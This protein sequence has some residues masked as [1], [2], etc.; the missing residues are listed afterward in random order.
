METSPAVPQ[1]AFRPSLRL[2]QLHPE[3]AARQFLAAVLAPF[4]ATRAA[5]LAVAW[6]SS[7]FPASFL[8]YGWGYPIANAPAR[9]WAFVR[10]PLADFWGRWDTHWYLDIAQHGYRLL[11][12][13]ATTQNNVAFFPLYPF[14]LSLLHALLPR[15]WQGPD[16]LFL[17]GVALSNVLT[18]AAL[19]Q[20][21]ELIR[22]KWQDA[23][24]ARRA[25][26]YLLLF[27][28]AFF[29][30]AVYSE[31]LF[32]LLSVLFFR[33]AEQRRWLMAGGA[34]MLLSLT[35]PTGVLLVL[36]LAWMLFDAGLNWRDW[37]DCRNLA[38]LALAPIGLALH[39]LHLAAITGDAL[40]LFHAQTPWHRG[41]V[42]PWRTLL[43]PNDF[44][45][46]MGP[47]EAVA[48]ALF[49]GMG[50]WLLRLRRDR[51]YGLFVLVSLLPIL[52]SGTFGSTTRFVVV[53]FP[54]FAALAA[55]TRSE[56]AER[57]VVVPFAVVQA[58][59]A[60]A[61]GR[62]HWVA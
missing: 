57:M 27:P 33:W 10:W 62:F 41:L 39:A 31:S 17:V 19:W 30:G 35:R 18:L 56:L 1:A 37:R 24:V 42:P 11:G 7:W 28:T 61:W 38:A 20:L 5:L 13:L 25:V 48:L 54:A 49:A 46:M 14:L 16:S 9:G 15:S 44:H 59:L 45:P 32:L 52:A 34:S 43:H 22:E 3:S 36:P 60:L 12:P 58:L 23:I 51:A 53:L 4:I 8:P 40:A 50:L 6:F 21:H 55:V 2:L 29:L 47:L 26:F